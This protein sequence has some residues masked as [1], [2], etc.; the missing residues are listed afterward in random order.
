MGRGAGIVILLKPG[1]GQWVGD[2]RGKGSNT[3]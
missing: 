2:T 1:Q 3:L